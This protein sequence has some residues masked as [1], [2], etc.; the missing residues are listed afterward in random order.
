MRSGN[1]KRNTVMVEDGHQKTVRSASVEGMVLEVRRRFMLYNL[2][3]N[4]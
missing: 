1:G 3:L 2:L 4:L